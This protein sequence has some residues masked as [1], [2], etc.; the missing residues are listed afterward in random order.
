MRT[1]KAI[2]QHRLP[3]RKQIAEP[4]GGRA[5]KRTEC[6]D[7]KGL[8]P[9]AIGDERRHALSGE[10]GKQVE[11]A[12]GIVDEVDAAHTGHHGEPEQ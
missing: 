4:A 7:A 1:R 9:S 2:V 6:A 11:L 8:H 12:L 5:A 10:S 3:A